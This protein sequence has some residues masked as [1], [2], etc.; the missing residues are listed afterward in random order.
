MK[1]EWCMA[2]RAARANRIFLPLPTTP[3]CSWGFWVHSAYFV[4]GA[5]H[6]LT[7][8]SEA[9]QR[10]SVSITTLWQAQDLGVQF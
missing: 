5:P 10:R 7:L 9:G 6:N 8:V 3:P 4:A 1:N 2:L